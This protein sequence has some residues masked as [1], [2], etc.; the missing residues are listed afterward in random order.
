MTI[1]LLEGILLLFLIIL[2]VVIIVGE[3]ILSSAIFYAL[4]TF[5]TMLLYIVLGDD[6]VAFS[7][8]AMGSICS[9]YFVIALKDSDRWDR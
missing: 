9:I 7:I 4:F 8:A 6:E 5:G 3:D 2:A 1:I